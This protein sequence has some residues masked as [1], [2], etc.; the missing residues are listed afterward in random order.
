MD[1]EPRRGVSRAVWVSAAVVSGGILLMLQACLGTGEAPAPPPPAAPQRISSPEAL[2]PFFAA[3]GALDGKTARQPVRVLQIGDSHTAND[4]LSGRL[5]ERL[6]ARFGASGRG[7]LPAGIPYKYYRPRLVSVGE[8]GWQHVKPNDH[9]EVALGLD[10]I[11]AESQ[12]ADAGMTIESTEPAGFDR[13]AVEYLTRPNGSAFA[14]TIDD[15]TPIRVSTAAAA[16]AVARFDLPLDRPA[17]QVELHAVGRPPVVLLGWTV[18]RRTPGIIYENHGTIGATVSLLGQ[19]TPEA[20]AFELAERRP[21]LLIVAF[22]TN[23]GFADDLDAQR[24]AAR[25]RDNVAALQRA[26]RGTPVLVLGPPDGN[27]VAHGCTATPCGGSADQDECSWHEP[28]GL[29]VVREIERRLAGQQGWA[30]WDWFAAMG[31]TCS[32]DRMTMNDPPLAM[33][34]HV[35]LSTPGYQTMADL[36]FGDLMRAYESWRAQPRT[37]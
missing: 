33:P 11:A 21:A 37:S 30:Y 5:R 14:V 35:H 32:I 3:L 16:T 29:A 36:L 25:F 10:A 13:F 2:A 26:A 24:Y 1:A 4:S 9:A 12:P 23:E 28:P 15:G 8:S 19:V 34:D 31:G 7:W 27:R 18:E 6:Q 20:V 17:R 22:G